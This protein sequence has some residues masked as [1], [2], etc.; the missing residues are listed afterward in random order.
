MPRSLNHESEQEPRKWVY[1]PSSMGYEGENRTKRAAP[2]RKGQEHA[3][4]ETQ[5]PP[6][7]TRSCGCIFDQETV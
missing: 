2:T 7:L 5:K 1:T 6:K 4:R 3:A